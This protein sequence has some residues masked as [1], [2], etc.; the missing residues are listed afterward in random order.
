MKIYNEE[1]KYYLIKKTCG[2]IPVTENSFSLIQ[3]FYKH[4]LLCRAYFVSWK[5]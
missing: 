2:K 3:F 1:M 4:T 5:M